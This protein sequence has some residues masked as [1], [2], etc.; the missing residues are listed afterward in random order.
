MRFRRPNKRALVDEAVDRSPGEDGG[1]G[2]AEDML[3]FFF[4]VSR[5]V[6]S[7]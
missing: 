3:V 1:A 4:V 5:T 7:S 6:S 2:G